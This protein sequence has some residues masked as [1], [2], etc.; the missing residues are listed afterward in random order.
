MTSPTAIR[1]LRF[2]QLLAI[3][4]IAA[5]AVAGL[6]VPA[7][8]AG[9][10][11]YHVAGTSGAG[12]RVV[13][14]PATADSP[15]IATLRDG[16]TI[17]IDCGVRGRSVRHDAV[18]HHITSP[19]SGYISDYYTDT[20]S[21]NRFVAGEATCSTPTTTPSSPSS[22]SVTR[23]ATINYNEGYAGSCVFYALDR[24]HKLT[25]VYPKAFGDAK[26]LATS[27]A[28]NG[29]T[30][31]ST[32]RVNSLVVF[33]PGQNGAGGPTGHAGWVEQVSANRIYIGEM[34]APNSG[35]ITHRWL[36][37]ATGVRYIY[38]V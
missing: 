10:T 5:G 2:T 34:N 3:G 14:D 7:Q 6:A 32:P 27:A 19:V 12:A 31:G 35:V 26:Y 23:G 1:R 15:T 22:P 11:T 28:A 8:A 18:W 37:P 38:A 20:P 25:G 21:S 4:T 17:T 13:S 9:T 24:F 36:T 33:Q 16:T 30:V 29:W